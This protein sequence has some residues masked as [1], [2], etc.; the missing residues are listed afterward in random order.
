MNAFIDFLMGPMVW[1]SF[2]VFIFGLLFRILMIIKEINEKEKFILSYLSPRYGLRS[3][4]SWLI[5]FLPQSTRNQPVFYAVSYMFH[6]L[7]F[8]VPIFLLSHIVLF[9]ES[10]QISWIALNDTFA[11]ILTLIIIFFLGFFAIRRV[12]VPEVRYLTTYMDYLL[13]LVVALPFVTGFLSYHQFLA[14]RWITII[15]VISGELMLILVPFTRFSHMIFAPF[16]RALTGS[17][18]G[19]VRH[20][21]DW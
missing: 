18:F 17:E 16:T 9:N 4:V 11:D 13:I 14:Y 8:I 19:Y 1:I 3:I 5:P 12:M 7:L 10:F 21:K 2:V 20:A 6:L 15:H